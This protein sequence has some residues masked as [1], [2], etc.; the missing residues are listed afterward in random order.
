MN[1]FVYRGSEGIRSLR[2]LQAADLDVVL[3]IENQ[4]YS[5]PWSRQQ[6]IDQMENSFSA[7]DLVW[8]DGQIAGYVVSWL[9][10]GELE[11]LNVAVSPAW[12]RQR[13]AAWML[14][15]LLQRAQSQGMNK[16]FLEVR[17]GNSAA[18]PLYQKLG[19]RISG[20]RRRYYG[21]GED[22]LLMEYS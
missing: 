14:S 4:S 22:A 10:A 8:L 5:H 2:P 16:A 1:D 13:I 9:V 17:S 15:Q 21:D 20:C 3:D 6:F 18:I 12:R 7:I 19:F 11:I